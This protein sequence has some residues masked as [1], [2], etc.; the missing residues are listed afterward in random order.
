MADEGPCAASGAGGGS[1][2]PGKGKGKAAEKPRGEKKRS[3]EEFEAEQEEE[4]QRE[5]GA[6]DPLLDDD[7]IQVVVAMGDGVCEA[8]SEQ[9]QALSLYA[10]AAPKGTVGERL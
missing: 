5:E 2:K 8:V 4:L 6:Y 1:S 9:W 3:R 10:L 7:P